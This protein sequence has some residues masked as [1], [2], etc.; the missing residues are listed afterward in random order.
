MDPG[1][2]FIFW[3]FAW[4]FILRLGFFEGGFK[5]FLVAGRTPAE[6]FLLKSHFFDATH[7]R[8]RIFFLKQ[9]N[10]RESTFLS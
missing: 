3:T 4:G 10:L 7:T 1:G 5:I 2:F 8:S 9:A 6:A